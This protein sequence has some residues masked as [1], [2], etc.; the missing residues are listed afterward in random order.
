MKKQLILAT[1]LLT[2]IVAQ[3]MQSDKYNANT[4]QDVLALIKAMAL[5]SGQNE[6]RL[7]AAKIS[8]EA[9]KLSSDLDLAQQ[10][11][12]KDAARRAACADIYNSA[13]H[14]FIEQ[15]EFEKFSTQF[16]AAKADKNSLTQ[17]EYLEQYLQDNKV[18]KLGSLTFSAQDR[19][20]G[21]NAND[22]EKRVAQ[23]WLPTLL[24]A[25]GER[26]I[27]SKEAAINNRQLEE[28]QKRLGAL[29]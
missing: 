24:K 19:L 14:Y 7:L 29:K 3:A 15:A 2:I 8:I 22:A 16:A 11:V 25:K 26:M 4:C 12:G 9:E 6:A 1:G 20:Q 10:E 17:E 27:G 21:V 5:K 28:L 13:G 23:Q 18:D